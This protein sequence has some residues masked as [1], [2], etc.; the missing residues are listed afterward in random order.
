[1]SDMSPQPPETMTARFAEVTGTPLTGDGAVAVSRVGRMSVP[2]T[3][4]LGSATMTLEELLSMRSGS[5]IPLGNHSGSVTV[6]AE[7]LPFAR[8]EV[9]V[10]GDEM[11]VRITE[12]LE[13]GD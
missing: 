11:G 7:D 9:V 4:Q 1:M 10:H 2:V 13:H 6:L 8:G 12:L 3:V 5:L